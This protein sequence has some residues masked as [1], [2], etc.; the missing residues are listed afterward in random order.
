[1]LAHCVS[2]LH[3]VRQP[4][5][6]HANPLHEV[7]VAAGHAPLPSHFR[8]P[9]TVPSVQLAAPQVTDVEAN[10]HEVPVPSHELPQVPAAHA[11][12]VPWGACPAASVVQ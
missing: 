10:T 9:V 1:M 8:A 3:V 4:V 12:R 11:V 5:P 2:V 6:E 7:M